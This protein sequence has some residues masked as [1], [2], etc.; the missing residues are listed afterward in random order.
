MREGLRRRT[1]TKTKRRIHILY[2]LARGLSIH[3]RYFRYRCNS[4]GVLGLKCQSPFM[5]HPINYKF[6]LAISDFRR[7]SQ[8]DIGVLVGQTLI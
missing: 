3:F 2:S 4:A 8:I 6:T 7:P 5:F 1:V